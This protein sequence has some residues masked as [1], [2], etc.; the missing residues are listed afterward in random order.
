MADTKRNR[1]FIKATSSV[2]IEETSKRKYEVHIMCK[3]KYCKT[4]INLSESKPIYSETGIEA[5]PRI[6]IVKITVHSLQAFWIARMSEKRVL[7]ARTRKMNNL[8]YC[9][10]KNLLADQYKGNKMNPSSGQ[11]NNWLQDQDA[12]SS[13]YLVRWN[14][15]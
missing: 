15:P 5:R 8:I 6:C 10:Y 2:F 7:R 3:R 14:K 1:S 4:F 12:Y 9:R 11:D 13:E